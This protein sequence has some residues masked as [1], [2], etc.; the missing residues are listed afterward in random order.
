MY[1]TMLESNSGSDSC[2]QFGQL[3]SLAMFFECCCL[4][5]TL[6]AKRFLK[7]APSPTTDNESGSFDGNHNGDNDD[8]DGG[9]NDDRNKNGCDNHN[10]VLYA[11][12]RDFNPFEK[13]DIYSIHLS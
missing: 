13:H 1:D 9:D 4:Q 10:G 12:S 5:R 8:S 6:L 7:D 3:L 11:G 2:F